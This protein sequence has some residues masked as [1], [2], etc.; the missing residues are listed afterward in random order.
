MIRKYWT[1][2]SIFWHRFYLQKAIPVELSQKWM[3]FDESE[4]DM[5]FMLDV[6]YSYI[7]CILRL[8]ICVCWEVLEISKKF[9]LGVW[10][11]IMVLQNVFSFSSLPRFTLFQ[12]KLFEWMCMMLCVWG[13]SEEKVNEAVILIVLG[14]V[15]YF[16]F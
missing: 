8:F 11:V 9:Y 12:E 10:S 1:S 15:E 4:S 7:I 14:N 16:I 3:Y 6:I 13:N 2:F 5:Y